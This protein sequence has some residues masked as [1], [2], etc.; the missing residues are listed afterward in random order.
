MNMKQQALVTCCKDMRDNMSYHKISAGIVT[1]NNAK[2]II[3]CLSSLIAYTQNE[4]IE[5]W[6]YDNA[7]ADETL[8]LIRASFPQVHI[9]ENE[10]NRGFGYGHNRILEQ[11]DSD[12]HMVVN[13]DLRF[14]PGLVRRLMAFMDKNPRAGMVSPKILNADGTEQLLP[15]RQPNF[16][17]CVLSKFPGLH[18]LRTKYTRG[19]EIF[20]R[21]T[22][23][24]NTTGSFFIIRTEL[25]KSLDGFDERFFMYFEDADLAKRVSKMHAVVFYPGVS[26]YHDWKRDNTR[27]MRG[28]KIFLT[29]MLKYMW[30]WKTI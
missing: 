14:T 24:A 13:P 18:G 20:D 26:L 23:C 1:Y 6:I 5:I 9:I 3:P 11:V 29:S 30:K 22:A 25:M 4:D 16:A 28:I 7:S 19:D 2:V 10:D 21:P 27:S 15:K 12:Y 8:D 17:Y